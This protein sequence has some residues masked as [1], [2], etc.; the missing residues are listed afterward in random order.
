MAA[1]TTDE[2]EEVESIRSGVEIKFEEKI[3]ENR[4]KMKKVKM[5]LQQPE[6]FIIKKKFQAQIPNK[7]GKKNEEKEE[8]KLV[9]CDA[10]IPAE[11]QQLNT[12]MAIEKSWILSN[13][14]LNYDTLIIPESILGFYELFFPRGRR[15]D[16]ELD[17]AHEMI[18]HINT[19]FFSC[20]LCMAVLVYF[21][22]IPILM[23]IF[24]TIYLKECPAQKYLPVFLIVGGITIIIKTLLDVSFRFVK[25]KKKEKKRFTLPLIILQIFL[26]SWFVTGCV[27]VY[28]M[29]PPVY[30]DNSDSRYCNRNLY[31]FTF[32]TISSIFILVALYICFLCLFTGVL[33]ACL[34]VTDKIYS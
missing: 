28:Q 14:K 12:S 21:I 16:P 23:I 5:E 7:N 6:T 22:I 29:Y 24:G 20:V 32:W 9:Q 15:P 8:T 4:K 11:E 2:E 34:Y 10:I 27:W 33:L 31:L 1:E 25:N 18:K 19:T 3:R 13:R 26:F 17:K 30:D